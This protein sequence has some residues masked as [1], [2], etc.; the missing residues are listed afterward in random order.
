MIIE[1]QGKFER[2][3]IHGCRMNPIQKAYLTKQHKQ[4][5]IKLSS[6][7]NHT[8]KYLI[9]LQLKKMNKL[10]SVDY[11]EPRTASIC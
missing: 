4:K 5:L 9:T 7:I 2:I 8:T 3:M 10:I 6:T 11:Y 1:I